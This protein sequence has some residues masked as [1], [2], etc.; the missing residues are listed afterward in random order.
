[1]SEQTQRQPVM[2]PEACLCDE[3]RTNLPGTLEDGT[4]VVWYRPF[5]EQDREQ[6]AVEDAL[7]R[8]RSVYKQV[9][10][11]TNALLDE[12]AELH[13]SA[14][15]FTDRGRYHEALEHRSRADELVARAN[16]REDV[17][18]RGR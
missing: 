1:M 6:M 4:P 18:R 8:E 3:C 11:A 9:R 17:V 13:R 7:R 12:A 2:L 5:T 15:W 14:D 10:N 16:R